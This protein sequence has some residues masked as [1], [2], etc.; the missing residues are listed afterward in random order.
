[1]DAFSLTDGM[2]NSTFDGVHYNY[3]VLN[4]LSMAFDALHLSSGEDRGQDAHV[5]T[6]EDR[7]HAHSF[8]ITPLVVFTLAL[9]MSYGWH[10][11]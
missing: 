1:V 4:E 11:G 8:C 10:E 2:C 9:V 5:A 3:H 7:G 6:A